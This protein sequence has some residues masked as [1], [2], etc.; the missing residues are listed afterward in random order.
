L[1]RYGDF[2]IDTAKSPYMPEEVTMLAVVALAALALLLPAAAPP[3]VRPVALPRAAVVGA[4]WQVTLRAPAAPTVVATG[5]RTIRVRAT[6]ARG[7]YRARIVFPSAGTWRMA[8]LL[9]GKTT[10]LGTVTVDVRREPLLAYPFSIAVDASG[11]LLVAQLNRGPLLRVA[12]GRATELASGRGILHVSATGNT[13][14]VAGNDG[15]AYRIDGSTWTPVSPALDADAVAV[16]AAGN[17]YVTVYVGWV[18]RVSPAGAVTTIAGTGTEGYSGDGGPATSAQLFHPHALALGPDGAIYVADTE[19]RRVRRIDLASGRISTHG[20]D[21][22]ITVSIAVAPDG[23]VYSG[24]IVRGGTGGGVVRIR[25]DGTT[26]RVV[27]SPDVNGVAVA[28]DGT[29]YVN[30]YEQRRIK[31][32]NPATGALTTVARG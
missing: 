29:V 15:V 7:V 3:P 12:G 25:P 24:D 11:S 9:R 10:R 8:A 28:P 30:F 13:P 31:R 1:T 6:G 21:V 20:G 18:K 16:D 26:T 19:N 17:V 14:Y 2:A 23:T 32:L 5:E 4:T 22:G 27:S